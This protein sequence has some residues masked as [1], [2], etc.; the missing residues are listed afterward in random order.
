[1]YM[2]GYTDD[3]IVHHGAL[4][5]GTHFV[6]KP[7]TVEG[8]TSKVREVL[9]EEV[10]KRKEHGIGAATRQC[11]SERSETCGRFMKFRSVVQQVRNLSDQSRARQVGSEPCDGEG[12]DTGDA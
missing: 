10:P 12:D 5:I 3:A 9:D 11:W 1:M 6:G 8:L 2:S 7:F 4:D